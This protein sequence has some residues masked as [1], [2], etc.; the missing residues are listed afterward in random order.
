M[1][2]ETFKKYLSEIL[3]AQIKEVSP[4]YGGDIN[5]VYKVETFSQD[6]IIKVNSARKFP[7]MFELEALGLQYIADSNSF[8]TPKVIKTGYFKDQSFILLEYLQ[9]GNET[10]NFSKKF[11]HQLAAMHKNTD[12][13][14][15]EKDNYI[16]SLPQYNATEN[17]ALDFYINQ[18]LEP[19]FKMATERGYRFS[20]LEGFYTEISKLIPKEPAALIHGDL[21]SGNYMLGKNGEP[22]LIDP[23]TCYAPREMDIALMYLFGGFESEIFDHYNEIFPLQQGWKERIRLWQLYYILA[24]VNLFGGNYYASAKA[25]LQEYS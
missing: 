18:R 10:T 16:G 4:L 7:N 12:A 19:Q 21:W 20:N 6:L 23:A 17:N 2:N 11:G 9:S 3:D 22:I 14:G 24:H 8:A 1:L 25:I 5:D 15:F 13:F